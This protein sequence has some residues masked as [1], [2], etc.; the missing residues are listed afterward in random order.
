[1]HAWHRPQHNIVVCI[2]QTCLLLMLPHIVPCCCAVNV[3]QTYLRR[4]ATCPGRRPGVRVPTR[5]Q[6]QAWQQ[7]GNAPKR[8]RLLRGECWLPAPVQCS[9]SKGQM[10][11]S[12]QPAVCRFMMISSRAILNLWI[13][14]LLLPFCKSL[15]RPHQQNGCVSFGAS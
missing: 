10:Q 15:A 8:Q 9:S 2:R 14:D 5:L 13:R 11:N 12:A 4:H 3:A 1:V 7:H 6:H